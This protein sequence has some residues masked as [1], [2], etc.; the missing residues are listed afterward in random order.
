MWSLC[1]FVESRK[2]THNF[3]LL[4]TD[5]IHNPVAPGARA[6]QAEISGRDGIIKRV[7][8]ALQTIWPY[9]KRILPHFSH[10]SIGQRSHNSLSVWSVQ[11]YHSCRA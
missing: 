1:R 6:L 5:A 10:L 9:R 3:I 2:T 11:D 4:A 8:A 7:R